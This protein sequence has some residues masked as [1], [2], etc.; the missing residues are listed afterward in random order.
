MSMQR[1][2]QPFDLAEEGR[3]V[4]RTDPHCHILPGFDDGAPN[5][6]VSLRMARLAESLGV[7]NMTA[8]PHACHSAATCDYWASDVRKAVVLLNSL[9]QTHGIGITVYPGMEIL[10]H[11]KVPEYFE[12][13]KL[14]TFADQGKYILLEL[15]FH[16]CPRYVWDIFDYFM[17]KGILPIVAHPE[18]YVWLHDSLSLFDRLQERGLFFQINVQSINGLWGAPEQETALEIMRRTPRWIIGTDSHGDHSR[19][20]GIESVRT[21]LQKEHIWSSQGELRAAE[22]PAGAVQGALGQSRKS[23]G[24]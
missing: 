4:I 23:A 17:G 10:I 11:D 24:A 8:T 14:L 1:A 12:A 9:L 7:R 2:N 18:R 15:G 6:E 21:L 22:K 19:F 16:Q 20:W 13:G 5:P 3:Y